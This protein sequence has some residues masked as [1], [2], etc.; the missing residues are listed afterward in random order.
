MS[1]VRMKFLELTILA[2]GWMTSI[3]LRIVAP[4]FVISTLPFGVWIY[5]QRY[6]VRH[7]IYH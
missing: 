4:S 2:V 6:D 1:A 5:G 7:L 3:C